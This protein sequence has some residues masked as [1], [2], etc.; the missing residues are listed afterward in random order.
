MPRINK[1][2]LERLQSKLGLGQS[3]IYGLIDAKVRSAHLPRNLAAIA[4]AAERGISI[5]KFATAEDLAAIRQSAINAAPAPVVLQQEGTPSRGA[6]TNRNK[7]RFQAKAQQ[8]RG[9]TV[10]VVH[11]R[12]LAA[13]DAVF[14]FV[15]SV[16]L[17]PLE[18]TQAIKLTRKGS[19]YVGEILDAA[20]REAAAI[21]VLL[22]PDEEAR[23]KP[24]FVSSGDPEHERRFSG[25]ARP[26][27]LFEA[28]MAF[29]RDP[30]STILVQLG[31]T[32]PFSDVGGR[33]V[34]HLNDGPATRQEFVTKLANA[35]CNINTSGTDW[36]SAGNFQRHLA[37]VSPRTRRKRRAG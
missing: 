36:L 16:G 22:T 1:Q 7:A 23:L 19:P 3:R 20:F 10:F 12:D 5:S 18:W 6:A 2:L 13:R 33:H 9:T 4:V 15:R 24:V 31:D 14:A 11:G 35:G 21:I 17:R 30:N 34:L 32:R 29:G 8:R 28:G 26:N 25:Q 27:V 37:T